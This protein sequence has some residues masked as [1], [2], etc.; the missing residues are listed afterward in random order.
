MAQASNNMFTCLAQDDS[1]EEKPAPVRQTKHQQRKDDKELR[2]TYESHVKKEVRGDR[3]NNRDGD[4]QGGRTDKKTWSG[5][6]KRTDDRQ[7]GSGKNTFNKHEKKGG[8]GGKGNW[9]SENAKPDDAEAKVDDESKKEVIE[10]EPAEPV[11]T[12]DDY[13]KENN[14]NLQ[15]ELKAGDNQTSTVTTTEK[16]FK[17]LNKKEKDYV[18]PETGNKKNADKMAKCGVS[19]VQGAEPQEAPRRGNRGQGGPKPGKKNNKL[20]DDD[21]P[22]LN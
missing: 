19:N 8:Q 21:F 11:L 10:E 12:L 5:E 9:G 13:L 15:T 14:L 20:S 2:D 1:D 6:G 3:G 18:E 4:K 7:S 16:G 17:V 22:T